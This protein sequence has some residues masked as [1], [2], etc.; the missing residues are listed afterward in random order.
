MM[1]SGLGVPQCPLR[2]PR[3]ATR[4]WG[5]NLAHP[6][7]HNGGGS[8]GL[9]LN[10]LAIAFAEGVNGPDATPSHILQDGGDSERLGAHDRIHTQSDDKG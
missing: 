3:P 1:V 2:Y 6:H 4:S 5:V 10:D 8:N 7:P 9:S